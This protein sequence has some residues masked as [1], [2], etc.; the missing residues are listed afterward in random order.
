[1]APELIAE[2]LRQGPLGL[3]CVF[4][5]LAVLRLSK[6]KE[7]AQ[8]DLLTELRNRQATSETSTALLRDANE[9]RKELRGLLRSA[10]ESLRRMQNSESE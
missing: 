1:M 6:E 4:L 8:K 3:L 10:L 7:T 9:E 2:L 5:L